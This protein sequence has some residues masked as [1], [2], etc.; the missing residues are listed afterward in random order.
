MLTVPP[1][2]QLLY[3]M[4]T[5]ENSLRSF[6][7]GYMHFNRVDSYTDFP[8]ADAHDGQQLPRDR[9]GNAEARFAKSPEF[10]GAN[11]Y[12][13]SRSRTYACCFSMENSEF[14][15]KNFANGSQKGKVC[16][17]VDF[18]K[19]RATL[20][21]TFQAGN[22]ALEYNGSRCR[23]IFSVNYGIVEY[24]DWDEHQ[25]NTGHLP[26]PITYTYLKDKRFAQERELRVSLSTL[27]LGQFVLNDGSPMDFPKSLHADFDFR[28]ANADGTI[29]QVLCAPE[30]DLDFFYSEL[31]KL[32]I[33]LAPGSDMPSHKIRGKVAPPSR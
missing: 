14:I 29:Q 22:A 3:K 2:G 7:G 15:W 11:Y 32:G 27:G 12:D 21:R 19:L 25:A 17:V 28:A 8:N 20:S 24:V 1:D 13:L 9:H 31:Y 6:A 23:Q 26:N 10:S 30:C 33:E 16:I 18:A 4:M 5:V